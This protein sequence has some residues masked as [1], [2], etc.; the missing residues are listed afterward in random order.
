MKYE[1]K[2]KPDFSRRDP[3]P[4]VDKLFYQR[5][6]PRSFQ[7]TEI[8]HDT[9]ASIFDAARWAP[10]CFNEQPWL[11]MLNKNETDFDLFLG[12]LDDW[13][14]KWAKNASKI[15]F[16]IARRHFKR[17]GKQNDW[18]QFDTGAAWMSLALQAR[19]H[20]LYTHCMAGIKNQAVYKELNIPTEKYEVIAGF[21]IGLIDEPDRLP[22][23]I[24]KSEQPNKRNAL[25]DSWQEGKF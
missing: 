24:K 2:Y 18:A 23:D 22:E 9:L 25:S 5:W 10:S 17:N 3:H 6:S 21:T 7:R 8:D 4:Q 15:G 19:I 16:I 1:T 12:L 11:F 20:G 14:Q 13:N